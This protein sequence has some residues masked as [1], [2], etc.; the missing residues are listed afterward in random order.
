MIKSFVDTVTGHEINSSNMTG[1]IDVICAKYNDTTYSASPFHVRFGKFN[2]LKPKN[3]LVQIWVNDEKSDLIM[4]LGKNGEGFFEIYEENF[5]DVAS[6]E[7]FDSESCYFSGSEE[8]A[9]V[10]EVDN[11]ASPVHKGKPVIT[12]NEL[13]D[14]NNKEYL[15]EEEQAA[16][17]FRWLWGRMPA[18]KKNKDEKIHR[19]SSENINDRICENIEIDD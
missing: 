18:K 16:G 15:I 3:R 1:S 7:V 6:Q 2:L 17:S 10:N 5:N 11:M 13:K 9:S 12:S 14:S 8:D 4:K 19:K